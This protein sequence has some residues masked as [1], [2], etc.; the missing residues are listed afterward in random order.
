MSNN[1]QESTFKREVKSWAVVILIAIG[2]KSTVIE[3]YQIPT[4]SMEKTVLIGDFI[5]G[6]KFP[7]GTRTPSWIGIPFTKIGFKVPY[8]RL[9]RFRSPKSGDIII[10]KYPRDTSLN[11]IK[12]CI[13]GPAQTVEVRKG[14]A[15]V[16]G[17]IFKNPEYSQFTDQ[18]LPKTFR[19]PQIFP[20]TAGNRDNF[21]PIYIPAENDTL[22]YKKDNIYIIKNVAE[23]AGHTLKIRKGKMLIDN[24]SVEYYVVEQDHYFMM[25]DN[26]HNSS[27]SRYWGLVPFDYILGNPV[28]TYLSWQRGTPLYKLHKIIRWNR[29]GNIPK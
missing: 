28:I 18:I 24:K 8:I 10:F 13:G 14:Q 19:E 27:D 16:D 26:R 7:F 11:Y 17:K 22:F 2:L 3:A 21:G 6:K 15:Y 12:R 23:L 29:I 20:P 1:I 4:G 25:G 5:L 9:P